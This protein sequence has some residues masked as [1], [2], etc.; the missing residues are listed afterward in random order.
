MPDDLEVTTVEERENGIIQYSGSKQS[1]EHDNDE[2][3]HSF[4][5]YIAKLPADTKAIL[6]HT[7][8][9]DNGISIAHAI[10]TGTAIAVT[11]GSYNESMNT[12]AAAWIIVGIDDNI[13]CEGRIGQHRTK[14]KMDSYRAETLGL[15]ALMT[16]AEHLCKY[17]NITSG[18]MVVA[19]DND[20]SLEKGVDN[21]KRLKTTHKYF[22]LFWS[23]D[24]KKA[25]M[26][27]LLK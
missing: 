18:S 25:S 24:E 23:I 12:G 4:Q 1:S 27:I 8:F 19:C 2:Q 26:P 22:D 16:A 11:D 7:S 5:E 14:E 10:R 13:R 3:I 17:H 15:L 9:P 20:A 21:T 6:E